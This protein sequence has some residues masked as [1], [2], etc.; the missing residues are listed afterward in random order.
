M[1][2]RPASL[3]FC[4]ICSWLGDWKTWQEYHSSSVLRR[5]A[6][7]GLHDLADVHARGDAQGIEADVQRGA[8]LEVGHVLR[9][10]DAGDDAL[11]AVAAGHLVALF[12]LALGGDE[13]LDDFLHA[14][15]QVVVGGALE[16]LH[17]DDGALDAVGDAQGGVAHVLGL[18]AEDRVEELELG[19]RLGLALGRD[20]ADE[21]V[22]GLDLGADADDALDVEV[23]EA[24][25][26]R[27]GDVAGY[28]LGP[29]L[30]SRT[31]VWNSLMWM[32]VN[33]SSLTTRS[34]MRMASS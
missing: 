31:S 18:L 3:S 23:V 19:R 28:A 5:P 16:A 27:V 14:G 13:D 22:A 24:L 26:A 7:L 34:E 2:G 6:E 32:E 21:D 12:E 1:T 11:V 17:V 15:R 33:M 9:R 29:S 10:E 25:L 30:V 20:L 8:V 4:S